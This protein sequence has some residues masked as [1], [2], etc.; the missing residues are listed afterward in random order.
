MISLNRMSDGELLEQI[1]N[2][3]LDIEKAENENN[4]DLK[5][6][7]NELLAAE[8]ELNQRKKINKK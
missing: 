8:N 4:L 5:F 1:N 2:L 3:K 7:Q 6:F